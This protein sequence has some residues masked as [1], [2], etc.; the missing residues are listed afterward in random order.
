MFTYI[1][2]SA[3]EF[4]QKLSEGQYFS[5]VSPNDN[6]EISFLYKVL[7]DELHLM[8]EGKDYDKFGK[9]CDSIQYDSDGR[10]FFD[11]SENPEYTTDKL[12]F[13]VGVFELNT[14]DEDE[15]EYNE[16]DNLVFYDNAEEET[17]GSVDYEYD[18]Y[19]YSH[20]KGIMKI[21][22]SDAIGLMMSNSIKKMR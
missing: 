17:Q 6:F 8:F 21:E 7:I 9:L 11:L 18:F 3:E 2:M 16:E 19:I 4:D 12:A 1:K 15:Y 14:E 13:Y 10:F 22:L 20:Y 5:I